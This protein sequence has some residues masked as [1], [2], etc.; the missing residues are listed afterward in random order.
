[1]NEKVLA[2]EEFESFLNSLGNRLVIL[3]FSA[4]WCGPCR[5]I[6]ALGEVKVEALKKYKTDVYCINVDDHMELFGWLKTK[7]MLKGIPSILAYYGDEKRD[8]WYCPDDS[9]LSGDPKL[10]T[11]FFDRCIRKAMDY[12]L[13][14]VEKET[15][16]PIT[17]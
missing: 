5:R 7:R 13:D 17:V 9:V 6:K 14:N 2:K 3:W 10:V 4:P 8:L 1:M 12:G 16:R 15:E 11:D